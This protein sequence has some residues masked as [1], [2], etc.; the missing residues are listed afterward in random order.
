MYENQ[1]E[2]ERLRVERH[3]LRTGDLFGVATDTNRAAKVLR[4]QPLI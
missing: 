2:G 3:L 4:A 1:R